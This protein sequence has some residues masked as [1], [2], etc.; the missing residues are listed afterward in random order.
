MVT[1]AEHQALLA[2]CDQWRNQLRQAKE[3]INHLRS[4]LYTAA[5]G[6]TDH[7][8][9]KEVEHY[10]NQFHIQLINVHDV[11][12]AIKH[13]VADAEHHPNFGHKIPHHNLELQVKQL[14]ADIDQLTNDFHRFIGETA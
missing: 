3:N 10:H 6:K 13:H 14:L 11:K 7:D 4:E 12:H 2:E 9:L 5:A 1:V 8:Y